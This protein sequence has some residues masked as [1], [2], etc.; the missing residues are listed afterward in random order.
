M[1]PKAMLIAYTLVGEKDDKEVLAA[2]V[3]LDVTWKS[4]HKVCQFVYTPT[5]NGISNNENKTIEGLGVPQSN[6]TAYSRTVTGT[7]T[8]KKS[9]QT[10]TLK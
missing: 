1:A 4:P 6:D 10:K 7:E 5:F 2:S 8:K 3:T 9:L